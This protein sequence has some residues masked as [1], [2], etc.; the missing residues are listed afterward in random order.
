MVSKSL[1]NASPGGVTRANELRELS[2]LSPGVHQLIRQL[3]AMKSSFSTLEAA[4]RVTPSPTL[5]SDTPT[6]VLQIGINGTPRHP[7][8]LLASPHVP[9][10]RP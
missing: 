1:A 6:M 3:I 7:Q 5:T 9:A 10:Q 8:D 4:H 2:H